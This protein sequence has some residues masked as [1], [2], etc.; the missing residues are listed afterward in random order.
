MRAVRVR[1]R[2]EWP[3]SSKKSSCRPIGAI[4]EEILPEGGEPSL[5]RGLRRDVGRLPGLPWTSFHGGGPMLEGVGGQRDAAGAARRCGRRPSRRRA[6]E[7]EAAE[8]GEQ[9]GGGRRARL[10]E[11]ARSEATAGRRRRRRGAGGARVASVA[12]GADLERGIRSRSRLGEQRAPGRRRNAPAGAGGAPSR[13]DRSPRSAVIQVPVTFETNGIARRAQSCDAARPRSRERRRGSAPSSRSGRRARCAGGGRRRRAR[14]AAPRAPSTAAA[15]PETTQSAGAVDGGERQVRRPSS[16]ADLAP[17][18]AARRAWRRRAAPRSAGRGAATRR[19]ASSQREH[20]GQAGGDV[21]AE[22][23][24]EERARARR[25]SSIQS[26]ASAYSTDE[27][28]RLGRRAVRAGA[29]APRPPR[30]PADRARRE[31]RAPRWGCE[32]RPA[33]LVDAR[34]GTRARCS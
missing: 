22:A 18:G 13:R 17:R 24:A 16:G 15:G 3:P 4:P 25:P 1:A 20:A 11:R 7:P 12:A 23:V 21:L 14:P 33:Q 6:G 10:F 9:E 31:D 34:R 29:S 8:G 5:H 19:S 32:E 28:R 26:C 27:E 30:R 2:S